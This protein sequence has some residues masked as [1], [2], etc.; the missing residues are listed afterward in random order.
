MPRVILNEESKTGHGFE[1]GHRQQKCWRPDEQSRCSRGSTQFYGCTWLTK[2]TKCKIGW[3][4]GQ[5]YQMG[6]A[7]M[8][9]SPHFITNYA[10]VRFV[11][12]YT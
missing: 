1:I 6:N 8:A 10:L 9:A 12:K 7:S 5:E 2:S 11:T 3:P 4:F